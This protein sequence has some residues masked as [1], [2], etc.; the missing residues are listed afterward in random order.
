MT[1][2][3]KD[4]HDKSAGVTDPARTAADRTANDASQ[5]KQRLKDEAEGKKAT[6]F[7]GNPNVDKA[8]DGVLGP[9]DDTPWRIPKKG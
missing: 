6:R 9:K 5:D 4:Q 3:S 8:P 2:P 7:D 1:L